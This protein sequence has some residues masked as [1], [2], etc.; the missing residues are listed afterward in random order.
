MAQAARYRGAVILMGMSG[1]VA[2]MILLREFLIIAAGNEMTI[3]IILAN[4]LILEAA[5]A[6]IGGRLGD[7]LLGRRAFFVLSTGLFC[8]F[9]PPTLYLIRILK[10]T[11]GLSVGETPGLPLLVISSILIMLPTS[12]AHGAQFPGACGA[13]PRSD[14]FSE[15]PVARVYLLDTAGTLLGG[16]IWTWLLIPHFHSFEI[17][18]GAVV[19]N[20]AV[21][22]SLLL[23]GYGPQSKRGPLS[24]TGGALSMLLLLGGVGML[25]TGGA[26]ALHHGSIARQWRGQNVVDYRNSVHGNICV[27][28]NEGQF[29]FFVDGTLALI[30]PFPEAARVK[31][32]AHIPLTAHS[33]PRRVLLIGGGPG[34]LIREMLRHPGIRRIDYAE[35]DPLLI[36]MLRRHSTSLTEAELSSPRL[37]LTLTDGRTHLL[38]SREQYDLILSAFRSP[39]NLETNRFFTREFFQLAARRLSA[40]G[41]LVLRLPALLGLQNQELANLT[42]SLY[43][44]LASVFPQVR[45]FPGEEGTMAIASGSSGILSYDLE[46]LV[47]RLEERGLLED[48]ELPW[49]IERRLH[50]GW[51][52]SFS[53]LIESGRGRE[54]RDFAPR[55][56]FLSLA[57]WNTLHAPELVPLF[58]L[59]RKSRPWMVAAA[60]LP[61]ALLIVAVRLG[62]AGGRGLLVAPAVFGTGFGGML[63]ALALSFSFQSLFGYLFSWIGLLTA[64]FMGGAAA[65][66]LLM[67][68]HLVGR[69]GVGRQ[70]IYSE[71]AVLLMALLLPVMVPGIGRILEQ[72]EA[73]ALIRLLFLML[74]FICGIVT[75]AQF[76]LAARLRREV[77]GSIG[78]TAGALYA[79]DL[80]GGWLGGMLGGVL[81]LPVLGLGG[82]GVSVAL[83]K[84]LTLALFGFSLLKIGRS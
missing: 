39:S 4:W 5:G 68:R 52:A 67:S 12:L 59:L 25:V 54:N 48:L 62:H 41:I 1:L 2:E 81:L 21:S 51:Q 20:G 31:T 65:G 19:L 40:E 28:E 30:T 73:V 66:A 53:N 32:Y 49:E 72:T 83:L 61:F 82:T 55:G 11:L 8:L 26:D 77:T 27:V 57:Y 38:R 22:L 42:S 34:G 46:L 6:A 76:P 10:P 80:M 43:S 17:A 44:S 7:R 63:F 24:T 56:V 18:L 74:P 47:E 15:S 45:L 36:E 14:S 50:P 71:L 75:G 70:M 29:S 33:D 58:R 64:L 60:L 23:G 37:Y 78:S 13:V 69:V 35:L 79:A 3:G 16:V 84:L 9:L